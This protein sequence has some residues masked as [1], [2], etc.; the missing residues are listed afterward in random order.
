VRCFVYYQRKLYAVMN[1]VPPF[2]TLLASLS[3]RQ[4]S[5]LP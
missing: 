1:R 4:V 2:F 5:V 3:C